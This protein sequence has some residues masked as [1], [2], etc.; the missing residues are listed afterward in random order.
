MEFAVYG[1][2][3]Y[4]SLLMLIISTIKEVPTG[5]ASSI[6][7]A[8]YLIPGIICAG[9]LASS[10]VNVQTN[11]DNT[12]TVIKDLNNTQ[13][14]SESDTKTVNIVLINPIWQTV[15]YVIMIVLITYVIT[16][17]VNLLIKTPSKSKID[18]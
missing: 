5:R 12:S 7:R 3:A 10:G 16:Q 18:D 2:I 14:W 11:V 9:I 8:V 1:F 6:S 17:M 13:T 4:S 15:H